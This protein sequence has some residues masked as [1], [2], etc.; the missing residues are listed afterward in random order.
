G[1]PM[2]HDIA[3]LSFIAGGGYAVFIADSNPELGPDHVD[4]KLSADQ[5]IIALLA[6]DGTIID[7]VYYGPQTT[8]IS[9]GRQPNGSLSYGFFSPPTPGAPN[10]GVIHPGQALVIN[11]VLALNTVKRE[12]DGST[13]DWVEFY[14]PT[15]NV[16]DMADMSLSDDSTI[17]RKYVFG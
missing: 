15:A 17:P 11:E 12:A 14:N 2:Q 5:G 1:A 8:D 10:P 16:I 9:M 3:P 6:A 7:W 13:P 4:F